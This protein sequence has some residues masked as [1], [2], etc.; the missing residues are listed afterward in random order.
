VEV[1]SLL[2]ESHTGDLFEVGGLALPSLGGY[3]ALLVAGGVLW[4]LPVGWVVAKRFRRK[5]APAAVSAGAPRTL[6]DQLL[7][8]VEAAIAG[9]LSTERSAE[10]EMLLLAYWRRHRR[11]EGLSHKDAIS[12][13][14]E[15]AE[16]GELLRSLD[17]WLHLPPGDAVSLDLNTLLSPYRAIEPIELPARPLQPE[18]ALQGASG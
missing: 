9:N 8:L 10:L 14:R 6:G 5:P 12:R 16:A 2:P 1:G 11:I 18:P 4:L 15:D 13:L 17:R 3:R 7:P